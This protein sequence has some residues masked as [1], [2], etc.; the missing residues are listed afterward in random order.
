MKGGVRG[1]RKN[2]VGGD[3]AGRGEPKKD[4]QARI[5]DHCPS[6]WLKQALQKAM[7]R[8]RKL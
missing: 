2:G 7:R 5:S 8:E 4:I 1:N 3:R 6:Q